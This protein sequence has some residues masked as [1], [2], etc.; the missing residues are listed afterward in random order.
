MASKNTIAAVR[1][2]SYPLTNKIFHPALLM[3]FFFSGFSALV[4]QI[5]WMRMF[6]LVF[7]VTT[8]AVSTVLTAFMA[9]L[10]LGS[11]LAGRFVDRSKNPLRFFAYLEFGIGLFALFFPLLL[12]GLSYIFILIHQYFYGSFYLFSIIRFL[13]AFLLLLIP[14]MLMGGTLPVLSKSFVRGLKGLGMDMGHLYSVNNWGSVLGILVAGF[15]LIENVGVR[16]TA[17][18]AA[19]I[20]ILIGIIS[21]LIGSRTSENK[22]DSD[23]ARISNNHVPIQSL[24]AHA[25]VQKYPSYI[26]TFV[27][28]IFA[29]EG[30]TSLAYEV[31]WIRILAAESFLNTV[32]SFSLVVASFITGL[33]LGSFIIA[34]FVDHQK[35]LLVIFGLIELGIGISALAALPLFQKIPFW[36]IELIRLLFGQVQFWNISLTKFTLLSTVMIVPTTLMGMTFPLVSKIYTINFRELGHR[37][38]LL[39]CLDTIG[40]IFG[41]FMAGFLI[42][43]FIGLQMGVIVM[44]LLNILLGGLIILFHPYIRLRTKIICA[45]I[46]ILGSFVAFEIIPHQAYFWGKGKVIEPRTKQPL[47]KLL[48]YK[49]D[50]DGTVTVSQNIDGSKVI[51]INGLDVAGTSLDLKTTQ[52]AQGHLPLLLYESTTGQEP[53]DILLVGLGSGGTSWS[54]S[55]HDVERITCVELVPS[56]AEFAEKHFEEVNHNVFK[57]PRYHLIFEDG[58]NYMLTSDQK[59]DAILTESVHPSYAGNA[60]LYSKE[61]FELCRNHLRDK[62]VV[63]VWIP[64]WRLSVD[65][66]QMII[67]TFVHV[68]PNASLWYMANE[69]NLQFILIGSQHPQTVDFEKWNEFIN[70][71]K[72]QK[73]LHDINLGDA[74][75]MLSYHLLDDGALS[76]YS[77]GAK[78]HSEN[79]PYLEFSGAKSWYL[80]QDVTNKNFI[81]LSE[82]RASVFP[83]VVNMGKTDKEIEENEQKLR[84]QIQLTDITVEGIVHTMKKEPEKAVDK[85]IQ[86]LKTKTDDRVSIHFLK[87]YIYDYLELA[88]W[89]EKSGFIARSIDYYRKVLEID[90]NISIQK[91][92]HMNIDPYD[93]LLKVGSMHLSQKEYDQA[94]EAFQSA[95]DRDPQNPQGHFHLGYL[96]EMQGDRQLAIREYEKVL[97]LDPRFLPARERLRAFQ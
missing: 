79:H 17:I 7:G 72:V 24:D 77:E 66:I 13:L 36:S 27:L 20:N 12:S 52:K 86:A 62:G 5:V 74:F 69:I 31:L 92:L 35:N 38:G 32:Y 49:E 11:Y 96:Y 37:I 3:L 82:S 65:D 53:K 51:E 16:E 33:A 67:K 43:T 59:Y 30:F 39:G 46:I 45:F 93:L 50:L 19:V 8:L 1:R 15:F 94:Q 63:S 60:N 14:T 55:Q 23:Q 34:R 42:I 18:I 95:V 68:F 54:V 40:S 61:Y 83:H 28:W 85:H 4:Y 29:I 44:A 21:F 22:K 84:Q 78:I 89:H 90:K 71:E 56:V 47:F 76:R 64:L 75:Q 58:R 57:D 2:G 88:A 26:L 70:R 25:G 6:S 9:G 10:A 48:D 87:D 97:E 91:T 73:D 41:S 81:S 80:L